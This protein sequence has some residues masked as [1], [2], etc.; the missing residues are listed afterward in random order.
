[1]TLQK[2]SFDAVK[3]ALDQMDEYNFIFSYT[4][5]SGK[6]LYKR[7]TYLYLDEKHD[8]ILFFRSDITEEIKQERKRADVLRKALVEAR[9]ADAMKTEFLSNVSHD[10]RTPLNSVLGYVDLAMRS[11]DP[12][13]IRNYIG[14]ID[15]AGRSCCRL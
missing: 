1:M 9:H 2:I 14:K 15:R 7:L 8:E 6:I 3:D 4:L 10:I 12:E 11:D 5:P 13:E